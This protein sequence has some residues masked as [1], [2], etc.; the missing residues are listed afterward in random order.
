MTASYWRRIWEE[1]AEEPE[2]TSSGRSSGDLA[3]LFALLSDASAAL[4]P[5]PDDRLLDIGCGVGLFSRHLEHHVQRVVGIDFASP[6]LARAR[7]LSPG[8]RFL[9]ADLR[10]LPFRDAC[11]SKLLASSV[12]QYMDTMDSVAAALAEMR[13]VV[14]TGARGFASGNPDE[15]KKD[16]YIAGVDKLAFSEER[17]QQI[18]ERNRSAF[19]L[20][21]DALVR[22]ARGAGWDA[23]IRTIS[24]AVWQASY[25]FDLLLIAR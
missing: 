3:Q 21:P 9:A 7:T 14:T 18:R 25:M 20:S 1:K 16:E 23:E 17:K 22:A 19:W 2:L 6:L 24:P 11:F 10:R 13:R 15:R 5:Q 12:L 8:T 4:D